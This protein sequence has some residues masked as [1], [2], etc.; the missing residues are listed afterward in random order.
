M[1]TKTSTGWPQS[2]ELRGAGSPA[3][4]E[5]GSSLAISGRTAVVGAF[6]ERSDGEAYVFTETSTG[7][8]QVAILKGFVTD[9]DAG[10]YGGISGLVDISG[11]TVVVSGDATSDYEG[12]AYLFRA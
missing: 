4:A 11:T 6:G 7:W 10:I 1:F 3:K 12:R 8:A 2:T 9:P 5:F